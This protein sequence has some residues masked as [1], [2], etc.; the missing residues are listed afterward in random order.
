M[1]LVLLRVE[2]QEMGGDERTGAET[3]DQTC[4]H[5]LR[6]TDFSILTQLEHIK[7]AHLL[8]LGVKTKSMKHTKDIEY[9]YK[10]RLPYLQDDLS[11]VCQQVGPSMEVGIVCPTGAQLGIRNETQS[12]WMGYF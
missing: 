8:R 5:V 4:C 3:K 2:A 6:I 1:V 12:E 9:E 7:S 11:Q 10:S